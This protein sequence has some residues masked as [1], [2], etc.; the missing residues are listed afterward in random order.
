MTPNRWCTACIP[1][2]TEI[3]VHIGEDRE[4]TLFLY[5]GPR[6]AGSPYAAQR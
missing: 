6:A 2:L 1:T 5:A 4:K 3:A